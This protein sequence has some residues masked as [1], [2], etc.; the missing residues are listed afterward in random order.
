MLKS[1]TKCVVI[2]VLHTV[3]QVTKTCTMVFENI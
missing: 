1:E 2:W 3:K